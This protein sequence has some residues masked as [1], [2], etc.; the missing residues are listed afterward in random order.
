MIL[1]RLIWSIITTA[2]WNISQIH[3]ITAIMWIDVNSNLCIPTTIVASNTDNSTEYTLKKWAFQRVHCWYKGRITFFN[4]H[5]ASI[6]ATDK[7]GIKGSRL[8]VMITCRWEHTASGGTEHNKHE[9]VSGCLHFHHGCTD[10]P[11]NSVHTRHFFPCTPTLTASSYLY[12]YVLSVS[13]M[14]SVG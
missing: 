5:E 14:N 9:Y 12:W 4:N 11:L 3:K 6:N 10:W 1:S 8:V 13:Y 7:K 2:A